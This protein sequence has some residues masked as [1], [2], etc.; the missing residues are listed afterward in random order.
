MLAL[1]PA[2]ERHRKARSLQ[3]QHEQLLHLSHNNNVDDFVRTPPY[4][5]LNPCLPKAACPA[6]SGLAACFIA[7]SRSAFGVAGEGGGF[8]CLGIRPQLLQTSPSLLQSEAEYLSHWH[9]AA[10]VGILKRQDSCS[11]HFRFPLLIEISH[12]I[13]KSCCQWQLLQLKC[14]PMVCNAQTKL[15]IMC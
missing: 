7:P 2:N 10:F 3:S 12:L 15:G 1:V 13:E 9:A 14:L 6:A 5:H 4:Q 11:S 8:Q